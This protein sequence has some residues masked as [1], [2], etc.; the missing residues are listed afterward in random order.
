MTPERIRLC[1]LWCRLTRSPRGVS[2]IRMNVAGPRGGGPSRPLP[3]RLDLSWATP[4]QRRVLRRLARVRR[5]SV[6][7]YGELARAVGSSPRAV[8]RAIGANRLPLVFP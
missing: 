6:I 7:T 8:G 2:E 3:R 5:G 4:F 1:G